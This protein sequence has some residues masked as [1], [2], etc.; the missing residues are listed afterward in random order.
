VKQ[1]LL[2]ATLLLAS[3]CASP[4][5]GLWPPAD[6]APSVP[7]LVSLDTWH[8]MIAFPADTTKNVA[9]KLY[10]E[11]GYAERAWYL[12]GRQGITGAIRALFWPTEGVVEAG[13]HD[14]IWADRT[15]QP[16]ADVFVF[17]LSQ[18]GYRRLRDY[19]QST[20]VS[21]EPVAIIGPSRFYV[22]RDSYHLFH[23][24]HQYVARGLRE[25]GMPITPWLAMS[26][27]AFAR[28][29]RDVETEGKLAEAISGGATSDHPVHVNP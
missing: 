14:R 28:Q 25:A 21:S 10:D 12:E 8:A 23:N 26:R 16:P 22:A 5:S 27:S 24:C 9:K 7:I 17:R 19:L 13:Q 1:C 15:P 4:V 2:V 29:L 18:E 3:G 11:W 20:I 6:G